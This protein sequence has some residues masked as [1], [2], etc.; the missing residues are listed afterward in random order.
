M[1][2]RFSP[3]LMGD[4]GRETSDNETD[5]LAGRATTAHVLPLRAKSIADGHMAAL[6]S[7]KAAVVETRG[8]LHVA[9]PEDPSPCIYSPLPL[10]HVG[11]LL[12]VRLPGRAVRL[13]VRRSRRASL[14]D[15]VK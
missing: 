7:E 5:R 3:P 10:A 11:L 12:G 15:R 1:E 13:P 8:P 2:R 6:R 14:Q 9:V 4:I